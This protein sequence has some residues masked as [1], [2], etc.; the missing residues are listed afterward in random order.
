MR[1]TKFRKFISWNL[2]SLIGYVGF[3]IS[4]YFVV[5]MV[6]SASNFNIRADLNEI[7]M[8]FTINH[9]FL[10]YLSAYKFQMTIV[11]ILLV[12]SFFENYYYKEKGLYGLRLFTNHETGYSVAFVIGLALNFCPLYLFTMFLVHSLKNIH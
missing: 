4:F 5:L 3:V 6:L 8:N 10:P 11:F 1:I 12:L 9:I 7:Y 2:A